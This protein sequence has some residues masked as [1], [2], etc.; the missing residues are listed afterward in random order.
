M[1]LQES[2]VVRKCCCK[3]VLLQESVGARMSGVAES[4]DL[5]FGPLLNTTQLQSYSTIVKMFLRSTFIDSMNEGTELCCG[6]QPIDYSH[7]PHYVGRQ[8]S[9]HITQ[10]GCLGNSHFALARETTPCQSNPC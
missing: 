9:T 7:S 5:V 6:L 2:V 1:L 4:Q 10:T 3:K 8:G